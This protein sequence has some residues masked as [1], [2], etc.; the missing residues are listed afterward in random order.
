MLSPTEAKLLIP[1]RGNCA[2]KAN[3][4]P[5]R[6]PNLFASVFSLFNISGTKPDAQC[7]RESLRAVSPSAASRPNLM[8]CNV[9]PRLDRGVVVAVFSDQSFQR[10]RYIG[11]TRGASCKL[12]C[13]F[14][15]AGFRRAAAG[16]FL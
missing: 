1:L 9:V 11:V 3:Y 10:P 8:V 7:L 4:K 2:F 5:A 14:V 13:R 16:S 6:R 15:H 12:E